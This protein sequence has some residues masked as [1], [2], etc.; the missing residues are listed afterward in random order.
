VI[1]S[2]R[3]TLVV[4]Q[5][6][7]AS[8]S[9]EIFSDRSSCGQCNGCSGLFKGESDDA[10]GIELT[11]RLQVQ[12]GRDIRI[13]DTLE[14]Q[15][16]A[17]MLLALSSVIYLSPV[18]LMLFFTVCCGILYPGSEAAVAISAAVGLA[19]GLSALVFFAPALRS[20]ISKQLVVRS[21]K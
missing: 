3:R 5:Q 7:V 8:T 19:L 2:H 20:Y 16:P 10:S 15:A 6:S 18:V 4:V 12:V 9:C 1:S 17:Q 14:L 11:G 13:G 21:K